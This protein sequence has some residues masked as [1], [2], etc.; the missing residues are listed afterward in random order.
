MIFFLKEEIALKIV[1]II[2]R[3]ERTEHVDRDLF[4][5]VFKHCTF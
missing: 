4:I 1:N 3:L 5:A 2:E